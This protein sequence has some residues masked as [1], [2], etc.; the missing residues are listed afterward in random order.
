MSEQKDTKEISVEEKLRALYDL[1]LVSSEIDKIK[2][3]RGELPLEVQDLEDEIAGLH[4]RESKLEEDIKDAKQIVAN[5]NIEKQKSQE[6]IAKYTEQQN[7]I[8]N[9]REFDSLAKEIEY[10][11]Q[12][13]ILCDKKIK[14]YTIVAEDK[15]NEL[16]DTKERISEREKDLEQKKSELDAIISETKQEEEKLR[17]EAVKYE[18]LIDQRSLDNFH[19]KRSNAH[20]GLAVV[21]VMRNACGGC[22]NQIPPQR[23]IDIA[24]RKRVILCEYCGRI[25]VDLGLGNEETQ[26]TGYGEVVEEEIRVT[27][28]KG[29]KKEA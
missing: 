23:R 27:A 7:N 2:T 4:T 24:Q 13:C 1:Q 12:C 16:A 6:A 8:K 9:N 29:R 5:R 21:R 15:A 14:E 19:K 11:E 20:N 22:F 25:M 26:K 17:A 18:S 10:E 28:P 3:L